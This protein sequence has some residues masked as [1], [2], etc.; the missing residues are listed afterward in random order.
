MP[1]L[2]P[3]CTFHIVY[4]VFCN[5]DTT[6]NPTWGDWQV[7]SGRSK[8][9]RNA[10]GVELGW[11]CPQQPRRSNDSNGGKQSTMEMGNPTSKHLPSMGGIHGSHRA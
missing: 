6:K 8:K 11:P 7:A 5:P 3:V 1:Y 10:L 4:I 9:G 2:V